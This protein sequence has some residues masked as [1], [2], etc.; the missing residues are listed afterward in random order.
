MEAL[1]S[2][3]EDGWLRTARDAE[4]DFEAALFPLRPELEGLKRTLGTSGGAPVLLAGSGSAV[5]GVF[6]DGTQAEAGAKALESRI[7]DGRILRTRTAG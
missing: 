7:G 5:F 3:G 4:N 6:P 1:V 2:G